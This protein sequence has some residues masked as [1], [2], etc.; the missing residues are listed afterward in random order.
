M[1]RKFFLKQ[2][3]LILMS[4]SAFSD[5]LA[6][7]RSTALNYFEEMENVVIAV[8]V[9]GGISY[10]EYVRYF[11]GLSV[12]KERLYDRW[13]RL[14]K[15]EHIELLVLKVYKGGL[16][17]GEVVKALQR[18]HRGLVRSGEKKIFLMNRIED[19]YEFGSCDVFS[20]ERFKNVNDIEEIFN[21][22]ASSHENPCLYK[23]EYDVQ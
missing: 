21:Q 16:V 8:K 19:R 20:Y 23:V 18:S 5:E 4:S 10:D 11:S 6:Y 15:K 17:E 22:M 14:E 13:E 2:L 9:G 1:M 12:P 3:V 7:S